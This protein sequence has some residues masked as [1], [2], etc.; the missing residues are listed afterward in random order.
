MCE[1]ICRAGIREQT[2]GHGGVE[3]KVGQIERVA[4]HVY[5]TMCKIHSQW[6]AAVYTAQGAQLGALW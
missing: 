1:P 2:C 5:T 3:G 6:E 4:S